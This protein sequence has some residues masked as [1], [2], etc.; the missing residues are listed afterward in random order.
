MASEKDPRTVSR[1]KFLSTAAT[2]LSGLAL[3]ACGAGGGGGGGAGGESGGAATGA[4][5]GG[6]SG[7]GASGGGATGGKEI[8][9]WFWDDGIKPAIEAFHKA[10]N[11]VRVKFEKL[12]FDDTHK[13]L[14]TS[15]AAGGGAPDVCALEIGL[16]GSFSGKGGLADL[17]GAPYDGGQYEN[18]MVKYK[19]IQGSTQDGRL[20]AMPWDIGPAGIW[21]R[22]DLFEKA[23]LPT[24]PEE[25]QNRVKTWDDLFQLGEDLRKA[26]PNTALFADAI[27]NDVFVPM[28][29]Q[30]GHGWFNG[31]KLLFQ[32]KA[33]KPL[34]RAVEARERG[35]DAKI[36]WWGA[37][38]NAGMKKDAFAG[39]GVACWMQSGLTRDQPQ[40]VG[41]WR[42]IHAPEGDYNWGGSFLSIPE[43]GKN[44]EAA[45]EFVKFLCCT[46]DGQNA[47][48]KASGI[49]PAYKPA[50]KDPA[51]DQPVDFFG[52]QKAHRLWLDIADKV[53]ANVVHPSDR[54]ANDILG[55]ELTKVKKEGKDP[56]QAV[57]DATAEATKR[58][59]GIEA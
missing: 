5:T 16:I 39:M 23:K 38:F 19:W 53:P 3:A 15:L 11:N 2:A 57:K 48:F 9:V 24:A 12:S 41:K 59:R 21:Y 47:I 51:Y 28:V 55:A 29:E 10:Q 6:A 35:I 49:F 7:G 37:E 32:E 22:A 1:R 27:S 42:V 18:D 58:I 26:T 54:Q 31:N 36:D 52:G 50:W 40:T 45:W 25:V 30:Q 4:T 34:Q 8:T 14:L 17:K 56:A 20:I 13:K 43:Q 33:L 44:K 46:A